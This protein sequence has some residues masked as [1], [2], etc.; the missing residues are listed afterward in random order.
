[1]EKYIHIE[2]F[3]HSLIAQDRSELVVCN[4]DPCSI[5]CEQYSLSFF[6]GKL[7][8]STDLLFLRIHSFVPYSKISHI[9]LALLHKKLSWWMCRCPANCSFVSVR[10]NIGK[11]VEITVVTLNWYMTQKK[12]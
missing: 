11:A 12:S 6:T 7:V 4:D 10:D 3:P 5:S 1:M 2:K 9:S 8:A